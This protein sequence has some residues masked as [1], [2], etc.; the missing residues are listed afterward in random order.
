MNNPPA[1]N[2]F[3]LTASR[4]LWLLCLCAVMTV[5]AGCATETTPVRN[6][7][8]DPYVPSALL[9]HRAGQM[10]SV[11]YVGTPLSVRHVTRQEGAGKEVMIFDE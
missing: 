3:F 10:V 4:P 2:W 9:A 11:A 8:Y 1:M 7:A 6:V 5:L